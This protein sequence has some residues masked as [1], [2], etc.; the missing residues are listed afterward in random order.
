[1]KLLLTFAVA[2]YL[3]LCLGAW[4]YGPVPQR[5]LPRIGM[6]GIAQEQTI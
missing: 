6:A 1:M 3:G 4:L 2:L 5:P